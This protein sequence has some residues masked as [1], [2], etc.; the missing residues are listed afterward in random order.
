MWYNLHVVLAVQQKQPIRNLEKLRT[1]RDCCPKIARKK[2]HAISIKS[3][4][5]DHLHLALRGN[6]EQSPEEIA[7]AFQ[8]NLAF[9]L[10]QNAVWEYNYYVGTFGEYDMGAVRQSVSPE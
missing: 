8:N 7:L 4:M 2:G 9:A 6:P 5:P 3:V 1:A 10:G